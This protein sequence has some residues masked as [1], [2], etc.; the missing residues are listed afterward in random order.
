MSERRSSTICAVVERFLNIVVMTLLNYLTV[1][2]TFPA[3]HLAPSE[4][5]DT[6]TFTAV[7]KLWLRRQVAD[8]S[9]T[10][11]V[12]LQYCCGPRSPDVS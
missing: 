3:A 10:A 12:D 9:K 2:N 5:P 4:R 8:T 11:K 6:M 1:S 7:W